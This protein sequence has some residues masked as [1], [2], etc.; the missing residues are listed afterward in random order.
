MDEK[1]MRTYAFIGYAMYEK[2][3]T[4]EALD[5]ISG[6][7]LVMLMDDF[8]RWCKEPPQKKEDPEDEIKTLFKQ[9]TSEDANINYT[10]FEYGYKLAE[11]VALAACNKPHKHDLLDYSVGRFKFVDKYIDL[12]KQAFQEKLQNIDKI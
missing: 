7:N 10:S 6:F 2:G 1:R 3:Y 9:Y 8:E 11:N 5:D 12:G 4:K